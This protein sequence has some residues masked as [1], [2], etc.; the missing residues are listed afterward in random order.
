MDAARKRSQE[1]CVKLASIHQQRRKFNTI[2]KFAFEGK[3]EIINI[4]YPLRKFSLRRCYPNYIGFLLNK[5]C[6]ALCFQSSSCISK[7]LT[8]LNQVREM[9]RARDSNGSLLLTL[10]TDELLQ[11]CSAHTLVPAMHSSPQSDICR[12]LWDQLGMQFIHSLLKLQ[13]L[14]FMN[15]LICCAD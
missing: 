1:E 4:L 2:A 7:L 11:Y 10:I 6:F 12:M 9:L 3:Q 13:Y 8:Y 15:S 5:D 14:S